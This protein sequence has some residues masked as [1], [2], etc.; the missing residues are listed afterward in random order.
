[1]ATVPVIDVAAA[2]TGGFDVD[3]LELPPPPHAASENAN[4]APNASCAIPV[5]DR[6]F[7]LLWSL[8][9]DSC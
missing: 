9:V 5:F 8:L 2:V 7:I 3:A 6:I 1:M 4:E